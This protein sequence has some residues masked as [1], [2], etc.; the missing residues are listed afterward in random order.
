M[1]ALYA[2]QSVERDNSV[3]IETQL[4]YCR[5]MIKPNERLEKVQEYI[6]LGCSGGN[7]NRNGFQQLL[8]DIS[9]GKITKVITYKLDRISRSLNDFVG[10]L[11]VFKENKV[12][13]VSSQE[14]FDTSSIYGD[15]ILKILIVF[16]EFE[17]TSIINRVRDAYEKR[18]DMG[19]YMG[20][21]RQYGFELEDAIH[22]GIKTKIYVPIKEEVE[23][24]KLIF[25]LYSGEQ[26]SLRQVQKYLLAHNIKPLQGKDWTTAKLSNIIKNPVYV[27]A[28]SDVYDY[29]I[30]KGVRI[31]NNINEFTGTNGAQLYGKSTH[32]PS[33]AD[34]SDMKIVLMQHEGIISS[35]IWLKCQLK[36]EQ[37]KQV[38][39]SISNKTS[40]L[41]GKLICENCGHTLTTIK[42]RK[43]DGKYRRYFCCTGRTNKKVCSGTNY[44]IYADDMEKF[45]YK[46][47]SDKLSS[48]GS[49]KKTVSESGKAELN[50]L[51]IQ[52]REIEA[53]ESAL[54]EKL[55]D[56]SLNNALTQIANKKAEELFRQKQIIFDKISELKQRDSQ[57]EIVINLSQKWKS[58]H[59]EEK[60]AVTNILIKNIIVYQ[61]GTLEIIWKI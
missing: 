25:E 56:G 52:Q 21:R 43:S 40:W 2:R 31:V 30:N 39:N 12:E 22:N 36:I 9:H 60:K 23:Q 54:G 58:A 34:W 20:G 11:Q 47:I 57:V 48:L 44:T 24:L 6:D 51:K 17:R 1:I 49:F 13:F 61:D 35:D 8:N 59:F 26:V 19:L 50:A 55:L 53:Q 28:D 5:A 41:A 29:F 3:S 42:S 10:I 18:T 16:A 46:C 27:K 15:L 7:I 14:S 32:D 38:G 33:L 37:N 45:V 4:Y